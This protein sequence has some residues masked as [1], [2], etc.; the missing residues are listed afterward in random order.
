M[1]SR[2][3]HLG[4]SQTISLGKCKVYV[5]RRLIRLVIGLESTFTVD[6]KPIRG[7]NS[8]RSAGRNVIGPESTFAGKSESRTVYVQRA[9]VDFQSERYSVPRERQQCL[10]K[11]TKEAKAYKPCQTTDDR[12]LRDEKKAYNKAKE[13]CRLVTSTPTEVQCLGQLIITFG[14]YNGKS[15]KWL[16]ENDDG[17]IKYVL[18]RHV[19]E[20]RHP[21]NIAINDRWIKDYLLRYVQLLPPVSC[22][23]EM[24]VDKAI[25]GQGRFRSFTFMEMWQWYSLH[26]VFQTVPHSGTDQERKMAQE[27]YCSVRQWLVMKEEDITTKSLKRFRKYILDREVG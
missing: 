8:L 14:K 10:L 7:P 12:D 15:F 18:D 13:R 26:K 3:P 16:V 4:N 2:F 5:Q 24:N 22:H 17:Y 11:A 23:L 19:K 20:C 21:D 25:Y 9:N 1:Q 6:S 27:A